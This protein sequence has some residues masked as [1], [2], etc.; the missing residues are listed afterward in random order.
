MYSGNI[1]RS[2]QGGSNRFEKE[3]GFPSPAQDH[4]EKRLSLDEHIVRHPAATYFVRVEGDGMQK[5]GILSGDIL[6][7]DRS[8]KPVSGHIVIV[9]LDARYTVKRLEKRSR[10]FYLCSE[11]SSANDIPITEDLDY[12][13]WGVVTHAIHKYV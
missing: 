11:Q 5:A 2:K 3:T 7:V 9:L 1:D 12:E 4:Y 6:V 10:A 8:L 13:V